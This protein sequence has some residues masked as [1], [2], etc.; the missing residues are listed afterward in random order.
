MYQ[1][2]YCFPENV[3][4]D[5]SEDICNVK[6]TRSCTRWVLLQG[7]FPI[8]ECNLDHAI[9]RSSET[10]DFWI[11]FCE[12]SMGEYSDENTRLI[13]NFGV[14]SNSDLLEKY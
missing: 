1:Q 5:P 8:S 9:L 6:C 11:N 14:H 12:K 4:L 10:A 3:S 2:R 13:V 7:N